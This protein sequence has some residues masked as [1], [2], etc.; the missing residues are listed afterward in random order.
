MNSHEFYPTGVE[1]QSG[2]D[3]L[4]SVEMGSATVPVAAIGVPP[5][6][7]AAHT[8]NQMV[9]IPRRSTGRWDADQS[10]RDA[11]APRC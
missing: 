8:L 10:V 7:S 11:R 3:A 9:I 1:I 2:R 4:T 5:M 6:A